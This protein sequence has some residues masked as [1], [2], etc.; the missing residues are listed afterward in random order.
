MR[1]R[2]WL[3]T[4]TSIGLMAMLPLTV[5][6]QDGDLVAAYQAYAAAQASGDA[7]ALEAAQ[8]TLTELCIVAGYPSI[9]ECIAAINARAQPARRLLEA[10]PDAGAA[11]AEARSTRPR[12]T[13][14]LPLTHRPLL[15]HR[16]PPMHRPPLTHRPPPMPRPL[17]THRLPLMHRPLPTPRLPLPTQ[18]AAA[19]AQAALMHRLRRCTGCR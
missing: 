19:D 16:L 2:N 9:D 14:R 6:A 5:R 18:Q 4:G 12:R 17:L 8:G 15:T 1:L 10:A 7:A 13:P 11:Q 3:L